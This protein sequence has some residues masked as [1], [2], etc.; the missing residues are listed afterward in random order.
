MVVCGCSGVV[1]VVCLCCWRSVPW[2]YRA[3]TNWHAFVADRTWLCLN[4]RNYKHTRFGHS[5]YLH[6]ACSRICISHE[7]VQHWRRGP[8]VFGH[9]RICLGRNCVGWPPARFCCG[10]SSAVVWCAQWRTVGI[11]TSGV[12]SKVRNKRDREFA[13]AELCSA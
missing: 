1:A 5:T 6:W 3:L 8:N 7:L 2:T 4:K 10:A 13:V 11:A 12:A 9:D